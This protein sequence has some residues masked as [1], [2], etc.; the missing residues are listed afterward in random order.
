MVDTVIMGAELDL[1]NS[2]HVIQDA[3]QSSDRATPLAFLM[4]AR[5]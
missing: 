3:L 4:R 2:I 5:T 1:D